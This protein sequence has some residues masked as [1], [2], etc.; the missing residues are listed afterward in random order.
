MILKTSEHQEQA[1]LI[2]LCKLNEKKYPELALLFA[3]P[4]GGVRHI[5]TAVKLKAEGVKSGV[6]DLF[7][8]VPRGKYHGLFIEM[9]AAK[10]KLSIN[11]SWWISA[12]SATGYRVEVC[13][14]W[15]SAAKVI[16]D[17]LGGKAE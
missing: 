12:L 3:V 5:G 1:A 8:P 9:K 14:G 13:Y 16:E 6:P 10:G 7:L 11:Q 4:N 2:K 17:Y 15:E